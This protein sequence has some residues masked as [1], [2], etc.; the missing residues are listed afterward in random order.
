M[1][2]VPVIIWDAAIKM[3]KINLE[4][5]PDPDIYII[6]EKDTRDGTL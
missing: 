4:L 5:I 3:I 6:F 1:D 2:Q